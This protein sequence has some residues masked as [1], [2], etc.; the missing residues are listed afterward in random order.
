M[1]TLWYLVMSGISLYG[2]IRLLRKIAIILVLGF[3]GKTVSAKLDAVFGFTTRLGRWEQRVAY[4]YVAFKYKYQYIRAKLLFFYIKPPDTIELKYLPD[5]PQLA[6]R[7]VSTIMLIGQVLFYGFSAL[8][9]ATVVAFF[10][11][12]NALILYCIAL[13]IVAIMIIWP[14]L[15]MH[16]ILIYFFEPRIPKH[17]IQERI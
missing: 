8:I 11:V 9:F 6:R 15:A 4:R 13:S 1:E 3:R 12:I 17:A 5:F 10:L 2:L 16:P 7:H 14:K